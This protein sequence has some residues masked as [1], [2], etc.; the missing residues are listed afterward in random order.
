MADGLVERL[1]LERDEARRLTEERSHAFVQYPILLKRIADIDPIQ[2]GDDD[3]HC[4]FCGCD[5]LERQAKNGRHGD[6]CL[7]QHASDALLVPTGYIACIAGRTLFAPIPIYGD[8][9]K[10]EA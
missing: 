4:F 5:R 7:W 3:E 6:D 1:T 10:R 8:S 2:Y 9:A